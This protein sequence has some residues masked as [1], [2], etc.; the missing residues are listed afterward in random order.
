MQK[1][2][3]FAEKTYLS[4]DSV[5]GIDAVGDISELETRG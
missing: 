5:D 4:R 2:R 1:S 3:A